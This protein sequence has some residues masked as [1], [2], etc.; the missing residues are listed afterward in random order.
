MKSKSLTSEVCKGFC[1]YFKP[2][3]EEDFSCMGLI[4]AERLVEWGIPVSMAASPETTSDKGTPEM[5]G[6]ETSGMLKNQ[7]CTVCPFF[8]NDCDYID[9][10]RLN[11]FDVR[12]VTA[13]PCGGF[14]FLGLLIDRKII[15]IR[16][17]K[18]VV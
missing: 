11:S 2:S 8:E 16:D 18:Q 6:E 15:D 1:Q 13:Q 17:I 4:V 5:P 14:I 10:H 7:I 3:K 12:K 9:A